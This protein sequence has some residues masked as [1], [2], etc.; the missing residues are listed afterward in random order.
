MKS[1]RVMQK[2]RRSVC[3]SFRT[4]TVS[5]HMMVVGEKPRGAQVS[6]RLVKLYGASAPYSVQI[7]VVVSYYHY[8]YAG[9]IIMSL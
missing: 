4:L 9:V 6:Q 8:H 2:N 1:H 5:I 3:S 7:A